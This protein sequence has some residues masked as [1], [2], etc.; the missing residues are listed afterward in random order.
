MT[1]ENLALIRQ[2]YPADEATG[3]SLGEVRG[4]WRIGFK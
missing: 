2:L 3:F 4:L 1:P